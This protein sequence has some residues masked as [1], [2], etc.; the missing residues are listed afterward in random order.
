MAKIVAIFQLISI[1]LQ[2]IG[3]VSYQEI[4]TQIH[5]YPQKIHILTVKANHDVEIGG[6]LSGD[7]VFGFESMLSM[8]RRKEAVAAVN[9]MFFDDLGSPAGLLCE[10]KEWLRINDIGTPSLVIGET[11]SI[12][13]IKVR[14][15]LTRNKQKQELY[16]YNVGAFYGIA[17][18]FTK[19]YG[20]TNRVYRPQVSYQVVD[21]KVTQIFVTDSPVA[22]E[23]GFLITYLLAEQNTITQGE[24]TDILAQK[25]SG[26]E[27]YQFGEEVFLSFETENEKGQKINPK[28]VYQSGGGLVQNGKIVARDKE[29]FIGYTT[30]LQPRTAVGV[31][32]H[33]EIAFF[34][35]EGRQKA[36]AEGLSGKWLAEF[37]LSQGI[38]EGAY[39]DGGASSMMSIGEKLVSTPA[40]TDRINGKK[41]AHAIL[42]HRIQKTYQLEAGVKQTE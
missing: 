40:F 35:V 17:N 5:G 2:S 13:K 4:V 33:G 24:T 30:S 20:A 28:S 10:D 41:L 6:V 1:L 29:E 16:S 21:N 14:A 42:I 38:V 26:I 8:S 34:V 37:M 3:A 39:L 32:A 23:E 18:V 19:A 7:A 12:E 27:I 31:N 25:P 11:P 22:I 36:Q 15:F 9:G